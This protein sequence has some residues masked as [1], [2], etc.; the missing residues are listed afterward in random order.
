MESR[1]VSS[2]T[3]VETK[4]ISRTHTELLELVSTLA[5]SAAHA[6]DRGSRFLD[7][8]LTQTQVRLPVEFWKRADEPVMDLPSYTHTTASCFLQASHG[9]SYQ[10]RIYTT[11]CPVVLA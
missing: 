10:K 6:L 3:R 4:L 9:V 8:H 11:P 1:E 7:Y 2:F 5:D